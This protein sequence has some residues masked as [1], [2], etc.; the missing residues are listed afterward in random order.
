MSKQLSLPIEVEDV[1]EFK[2]NGA[3]GEDL[4]SACEKLQFNYM[5]NQ[6][7][8]YKRMTDAEECAILEFIGSLDAVMNPNN[9][10][11]KNG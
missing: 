9:K 5:N 6:L 11:E 10:E 3:M 4:L 7:T 8:T 1:L 2:M